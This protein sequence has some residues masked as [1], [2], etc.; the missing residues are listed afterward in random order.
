[1]IMLLMA[2]PVFAQSKGFSHTIELELDGDFEFNSSF[3]APEVVSNT[4]IKGI[5]KA[6]LRTATHAKTIPVWWDLF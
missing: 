3:A 4:N 2:A 1:M 5:G 6:K